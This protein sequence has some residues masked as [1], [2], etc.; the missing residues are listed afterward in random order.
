MIR[1]GVFPVFVAVIIIW[2]ALA[3][4]R[5]FGYLAG[6]YLRDYER[7]TTEENYQEMLALSRRIE[8]EDAKIFVL[9]T[10]EGRMFFILRYLSYPKKVYWLKEARYPQG[11]GEIYLSDY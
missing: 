6:Y 5:I 11:V 8:K 1:Q 10:E 4:T 7:L 9:S 3:G 2:L